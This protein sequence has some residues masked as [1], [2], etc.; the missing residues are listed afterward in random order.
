[1]AVLN[2]N[3]DEGTRVEFSFI[4]RIPG[5]DEGCQINFKFF[6]SNRLIYDLDFGWTN[7]TIRNYIAVT[8]EFPIETLHGIKLDGLFMSFEKHLYELSWEESNSNGIYNLFFREADQD[9]KLT[10]DIESIRKFG[11][12]F[13]LDWDKAP[14]LR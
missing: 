2:D 1:M 8:S 12:E 7:I 5:E 3:F 9:F 13:K 11:S 4:S 6:N 14:V 10:A